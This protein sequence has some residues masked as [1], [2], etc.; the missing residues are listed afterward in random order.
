MARNSVRPVILGSVVLILDNR[1]SVGRSEVLDDLLLLGK[2]GAGGK[3]VAA[4]VGP[5]EGADTKVTVYCT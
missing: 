2:P 3:V 1:G 4:I 5:Q